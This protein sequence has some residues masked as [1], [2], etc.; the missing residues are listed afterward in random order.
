MARAEHELLVKIMGKLDSSMDRSVK[1]TKK[2]LRALVQDASGAGAAIDASWNGLTKTVSIAEKALVATGA[3]VVSAG[4]AATMVGKEFEEAMDKTAATAGATEAEYK[5]LEAAA[6]E[7]GRTTSKTATESAN[8]LEYM[9]LAGWSVD[10]SI[11]GLPGILRLSEA[12][13][14][15]L[16]RTSDL[17]TDSMSALGLTVQ[18]L[19]HYLDVAATANNKSNQTAEMLMEAYI[20]VGGTMKN[21]RVPVEESA[22]ALGVL[23]NRGTKGSEA[24]NELNAIMVNLTTGTGQAGKMMEKLGLSAFDSQGKF[25]GL[26]QVLTEVDEKVSGL[27]EEQRNAALAAIGGKQ[28][29]QG[30]NNLLAGLNTTTAEGVSEWDSL[31]NKLDGA[32]DGIGALEQ[33]ARTKTDNLEGDM[34]IFESAMQ[35]AGIKVYKGLNMPLRLAVQEG[36]ELV[37][38]YSDNIAEALE[39]KLP[40]IKRTAE[41]VGD[42]IGGIARPMMGAGEF[43]LE[44]GDTVAGIIAGVAAAITGLKGAKSALSIATTMKSVGSLVKLLSLNP[45]TALAG[46]AVAAGAAI[47]GLAVKSKIAKEQLKRDD[48]AAHFGDISLSMEDLDKAAR[49]IIGEK[50]LDKIEIALEEIGKTAD[51]SEKLDKSAQSIEKVMWKV[52]MG[53][54]LTETDTSDLEASIDSLVSDS[55]ALV[56]QKKYAASMAIG[57]IFGEGEDGEAAAGQAQGVYDILEGEMKTYGERLG[58]AYREAMEDGIIDLDEEKLISGLTQKMSE[59][60]NRVMQAQNQAGMQQI[61]GKYSGAELGADDFK[62]L[63]S[64]TSAYSEDAMAGIDQSEKE[65]LSALNLQRDMSVSGE[66]D[67]NN[68]LYLSEEEYKRQVADRTSHASQE[69]MNISANV[70]GLTTGTVLDSYGEELGEIVPQLQEM[71]QRALVNAVSEN[72]GSSGLDATLDWTNADVAAW[73]NVEGLKD[74]SRQNIADMWKEVKAEFEKMVAQRDE[75]V[76]NGEEVPKAVKEGISNAAVIGTIAGD[77]G[78]LFELVKEGASGEEFRMAL[79][80]AEASGHEIPEELAAA[81]S[82]EESKSQIERSVSNLYSYTQMQL[83]SRSGSLSVPQLGGKF[84]APSTAPLRD[85]TKHAEGGIF[86]TPHAGIFAENGPE[87]FIP[88]DRSSRSLSI[89]EQTGE[90]LGVPRGGATGMTVTYAPVIQGASAGEV[91]RALEESYEQFKEYMARFQRDQS[92][93]AY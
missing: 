38:E 51:I 6:M 5:R 55:M 88:I 59:L 14:L 43:L 2:E 18:E 91:K 31:R 49:S 64:E 92:R 77:T 29:V 66:I 68:P 87:A 15:D 79:D 21:L 35:D 4:A 34:H 17:V 53:L 50:S 13:G 76:A 93:L 3:A 24:G 57:V 42:F 40:T 27:N 20:G 69:R 12:T 54:D 89:W 25:K 81:I 46:G 61:A 83:N 10:E 9:A 30:L 7:M 52:R 56:R 71:A 33:M 23:A 28:H 48:L 44:H 47:A 39:E 1:M 73:L 80:A 78:A 19:P 65:A 22:A 86:D 63:V 74:A 45:V 26:K 32:S 84:G 62:N 37:Y 82:S 8:A 67:R 58:D 75:L 16:A 11:A 36:T 72:V 41:D 85:L 70:L 60:Q 90:E